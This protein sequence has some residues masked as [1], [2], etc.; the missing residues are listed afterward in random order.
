MSSLE[1]GVLILDKPLVEERTELDL[2]VGVCLKDVIKT[3]K[4]KPGLS[5][6]MLVN[7][8]VSDGNYNVQA[9]DVIT[10]LPQIAGG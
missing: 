4:V 7:G 9:G 1:A 6:V 8:R 5:F 10:C 3:L 2:A